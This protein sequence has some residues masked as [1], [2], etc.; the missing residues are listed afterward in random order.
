MKVKYH[1]AGWR[2]PCGGMGYGAGLITGTEN[3]PLESAGAAEEM[4][5]RHSCFPPKVNSSDLQGPKM[6]GRI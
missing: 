4:V 1:G 3:R 2:T 5:F 6:S